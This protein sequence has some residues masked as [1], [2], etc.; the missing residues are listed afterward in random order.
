MRW[1]WAQSQKI[2]Q[3][4]IKWKRNGSSPIQ[5]TNYTQK[6][7]WKVGRAHSIRAPIAQMQKMREG[8]KIDQKKR[9]REG[10]K[11]HYAAALEREKGYEFEWM[12]NEGIGH[13]CRE[14]V[15]FSINAWHHS[16][17]FSLSLFQLNRSVYVCAGP[18][19]LQTG[20]K[21][22]SQIYST[23]QKVQ[24]EVIP[25]SKALMIHSLS[26]WVFSVSPYSFCLSSCSLCS[27]FLT[28]PNVL[29]D[30]RV[31]CLLLY[32]SVFF[33]FF[34]F[35]LHLYSS[36]LSCFFSSPSAFFF[37]IYHVPKPTR[38]CK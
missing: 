31:R 17:L 30:S 10:N 23:Q 3:K 20:V 18:L 8:N 29:F 4:E 25:G 2:R 12:M 36:H 16:L 5:L 14:G 11:S 21:F 27:F 22:L 7:K 28:I 19:I 38:G 15:C 37:P 32:F 33:F 1:A 9:E 34:H 24:L 35:R 13:L 26:W 6:T